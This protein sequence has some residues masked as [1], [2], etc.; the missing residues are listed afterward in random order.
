MG[1]TIDFIMTDKKPNETWEDLA[2]RRIREA[3]EAGEFSNLPG[4]GKPIPGIDDVLDDNWWVKDKLKREQLA[5]L[6]P[7]LEARLA[8]Q[9]LLESLASL[10]TLVAVRE[11]VDKVNA[12]IRQAHFSHIAGPSDGV[13]PLDKEVVVAEWKRIHSDSK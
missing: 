12:L 9:R 10:P 6:P 8:R 7:I 5:A 13:L 4:F 11:Q 2:E 3:Q 1:Q